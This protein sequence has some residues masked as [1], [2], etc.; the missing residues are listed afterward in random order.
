MVAFNRRFYSS[1]QAARADAD[2]RDERRYV[3]V[4]DQQSFGEARRHNHP[5]AVVQRFMYANS[6]HV[7]DMM[8]ALCRG[9]VGAVTPVMPWRGEG[10]EVV[11]V[12]VTFDSGDTAL[13]EGLWQGPG[14]WSCALSTPSRRWLLQPLERASYQNAG[15][16]NQTLVEPDPVD[17]TCKAGFVRQAE[18]VV[19]RLAGRPSEAVSLDDSLETMRLINRMFGV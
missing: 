14:A 11:L 18:A 16:R 3:H 10:T 7:I 6:I 12:H 15:E 13:Y 9:R 1:V 17:T 4:Q 2:A 5:E 19:A 8:R